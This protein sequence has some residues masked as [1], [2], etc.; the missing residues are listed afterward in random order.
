MAELER[1]T[2]LT[3]PQFAWLL[4]LFLRVMGLFVLSPVLG[5]RNV[6]NAVKIG[7]SVLLSYIFLM[8]G[9]PGQGVDPAATELLPYALMC[10]KE[11]MVGLV[12]GYMT[13]LFFNVAVM[14][15][16]VM[17]VQIGFGMA[18]MYDPQMQTQVS[19]LG[20]L[21]NYGLLLYFFIL[22]G[23]HTLIRIL[24]FTIEKIPVGQVVIG[25][26]IADVCVKAF[27][28]A[29]SM[30]ISVA[31]PIIAAEL[32]LEVIMGI[33]IRSV[34]Q[35]NFFVVGISVKI[36]V[37]LLALLLF[38][39]FFTG[40]GDKIFEGLYTWLQAAFERMIPVS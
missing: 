6:P 18:Q 8:A 26:D 16:Q 17:D 15:G 31:L 27:G 3:E 22:D 19:L 25:P 23:H 29:I 12:L 9:P 11:L 13:V 35:L 36:L 39:P 24:A 7:L 21:L 33:L 30:A 4:L 1:L 20:N 38:I 2:K 28:L 14:A 10:L 37:G 40:F 5:R 32:I 34:P